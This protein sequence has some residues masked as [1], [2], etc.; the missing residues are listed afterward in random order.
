[1][2]LLGLLRSWASVVFSPAL[3]QLDRRCTQQ[4]EFGIKP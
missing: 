4:P 3:T 1:M 2:L